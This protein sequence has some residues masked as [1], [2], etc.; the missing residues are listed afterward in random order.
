MTELAYVTVEERAP[1]L[2]RLLRRA[3]SR[4]QRVGDELLD[5]HR[6]S[7]SCV[8]HIL[9]EVLDESEDSTTRAVRGTTAGITGN[10]VSA[11]AEP[12]LGLVESLRVLERHTGHAERR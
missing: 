5:A 4:S 7:A 3:F 6:R 11:H 2:P 9:H 10:G 1:G 12:P 8:T